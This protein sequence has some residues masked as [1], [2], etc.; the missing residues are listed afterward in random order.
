MR[1][2]MIQK[3]IKPSTQ[4]TT[5]RCLSVASACVRRPHTAIS[6]NANRHQHADFPLHP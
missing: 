3:A 6:T 1:Q 2:T 5:F 4:D